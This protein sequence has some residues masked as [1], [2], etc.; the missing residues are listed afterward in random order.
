LA[1][2]AEADVDG[3]DEAYRLGDRGAVGLPGSALLGGALLGG[4]RLGGHAIE[5]RR[6][7]VNAQRVVIVSRGHCRQFRTECQ[8]K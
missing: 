6:R 1:K 8:T 5:E 2:Q 7:E 3:E 4:A